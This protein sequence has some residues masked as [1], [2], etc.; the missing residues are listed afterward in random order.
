MDY[1]K[2]TGG[3]NNENRCNLT[4]TASGLAKKGAA[5][6]IIFGCAFGLISAIFDICG[7]DNKSQNTKRD[8]DPKNFQTRNH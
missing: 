6:G 3:N 5:V 1:K 4:K 2:F 8:R 7:K